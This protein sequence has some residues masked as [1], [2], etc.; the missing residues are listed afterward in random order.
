MTVT[1]AAVAFLAAAG[2]TAAQA[3][4]LS[5]V[6]QAEAFA[7]CAGRLQALATWQGGRHD[8]QAE[9]SRRMQWNFEALVD[10]VLPLAAEDGA[11]PGQARL[12]QAHGWTEIASL[13]Q[14]ELYRPDRAARARADRARRIHT[15]ERMVLPG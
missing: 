15:C 10:A 4:T 7:T 6:E 2:S 12:W 8:P 1:L 14:N 9:H 3:N 5:P 13:L 11:S